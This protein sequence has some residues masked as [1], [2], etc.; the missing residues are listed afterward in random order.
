MAVIDPGE[1]PVRCRGAII[2]I[3]VLRAQR[4]PSMVTHHCI[5]SF[6]QVT[7]KSRT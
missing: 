2:P 1:E 5:P 6:P 7:T 4:V 3:V